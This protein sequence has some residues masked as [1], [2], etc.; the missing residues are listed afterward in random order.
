MYKAGRT[1]GRFD[2]NMPPFGGIKIDYNLNNTKAFYVK[3]N[4]S[5]KTQKKFK[6]G[7]FLS[8]FKVPYII[9]TVLFNFFSFSFPKRE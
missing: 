3:I 4:N 8:I 5:V 2:F 1:D 7:I 9:L 6:L